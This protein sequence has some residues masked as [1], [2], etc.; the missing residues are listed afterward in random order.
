MSQHTESQPNVVR[1]YN[2]AMVG[3]DQA[4]QNVSLYRMSMRSSAYIIDNGAECMDFV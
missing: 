3:V 1:C 2:T 4:D